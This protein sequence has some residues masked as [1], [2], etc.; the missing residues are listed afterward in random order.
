MTQPFRPGELDGLGDQ[1]RPDEVADAVR[2]AQL[3]ERTVTVDD[4]RPTADFADRVMAALAT[5]P[6]PRRSRLAAFAIAIGAAWQ[7]ATSANRPPLVRARA[8]A[9]LLAVVVLAASLGGAASLAAAGAYQLLRPNPSTG[10]VISPLPGPSARPSA[11]PTPAPSLEPRPSP[12][13]ATDP[14]APPSAATEPVDTA[15][16]TASDRH[17]GGGGGDGGGGGSGKPTP[18]PGRTPRPTK[19]PEPTE[20][21]EASDH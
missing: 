4:V 1:A 13:P 19:T 10:P 7:T 11:S 14:S 5:E 21:P 15:E 18:T 20:T 16:P 12:S 8:V 17:G 9:I 3:I 6:T 2:L